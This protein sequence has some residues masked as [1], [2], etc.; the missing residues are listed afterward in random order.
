LIGGIC[1]GPDFFG[2]DHLA[3]KGGRVALLSAVF[4]SAGVRRGMVVS[5]PKLGILVFGGNLT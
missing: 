5:E 2:S 4:F 3:G 1:C